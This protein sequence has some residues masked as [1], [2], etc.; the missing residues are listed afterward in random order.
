MPQNGKVNAQK[1][2]H[3]RPGAELLMNACYAF[4]ISML[5]SYIL[6]VGVIILI[7]LFIM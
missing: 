5:L 3:F 1:C 4:F 2:S 6:K 7:S